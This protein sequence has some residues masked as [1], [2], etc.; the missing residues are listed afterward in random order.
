MSLDEIHKMSY[1]EVMKANALLDM[2]EA[3][4]TAQYYFDSQEINNAGG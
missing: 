1:V 3:I 4:E 2:Q